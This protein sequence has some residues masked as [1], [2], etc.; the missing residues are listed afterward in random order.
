VELEPA[1]PAPDVPPE[2]AADDAVPVVDDDGDPLP[3]EVVVAPGP[4]S[5]PVSEGATLDVP[6]ETLE[7]SASLPHAASDRAPRGGTTTR[8]KLS[9]VVMGI[10]SPSLAGPA[11]ERSTLWESAQHRQRPTQKRPCSIISGD[12]R[13]VRNDKTMPPASHKT[14]NFPSQRCPRG[15]SQWAIKP[16]SKSR[17]GT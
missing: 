14:R 5:D 13:S 1:P 4:V 6:L 9:L 10:G 2:P 16:H 7:G 17:T 8:K 12:V 3:L 15:K 11:I